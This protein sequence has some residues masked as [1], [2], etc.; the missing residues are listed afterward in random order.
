LIT[1]L[2]H[3]HFQSFCLCSNS[4]LNLIS[5][6]SDFKKK[7]KKRKMSDNLNFTG[8]DME[9]YNDNQS[10]SLTQKVIN[11]LFNVIALT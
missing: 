6:I 1:K 11:I 2:D 3:F 5:Q 8:S 4:K 10:G 9:A 7:R